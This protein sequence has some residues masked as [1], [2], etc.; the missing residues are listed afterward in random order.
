MKISRNL[1]IIFLL[2]T[3]IAACSSTPSG[4][5]SPDKMARLLAD[6]YRAESAIDF[7]TATYSGDSMKQVVKESV[8]K[9]HKISQADF[10]SSLVWYGHHIE[11][12]LK[13]CDNAIAILED[14][15]ETIPDDET[16]TNQILVAGDS[17]SVWPRER[18]YHITHATPSRFV[19]FKLLPD[20]NW[21]PGDNYALELKLINNRTGVKSSIAVDYEDGHTGWASTSRDEEGWS[22][23]NLILD[24]TRTASAIYGVLE[25]NPAVGENIYVDSVSLIRTRRDRSRRYIRPHSNNFDYGRVQ[26]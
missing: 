16:G 21:E 7:N 18:F 20:D 23:V 13:V 24:S 4:V 10:D 2:G 19:T 22:R 5:L 9:A 14:Q 6:V 1:I 17:A 8:F 26:E 3:I 25:F 11:Q 12:Y 15:L